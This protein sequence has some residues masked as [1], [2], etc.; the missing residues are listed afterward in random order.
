MKGPHNKVQ[1]ILFQEENNP[2]STSV[3]KL[4]TYVLYIICRL[5]LY[6]MYVTK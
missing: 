6:N 4:G 1:D 3:Q 2:V 5:W